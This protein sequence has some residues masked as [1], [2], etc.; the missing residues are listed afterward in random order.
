MKFECSACGLRLNSF[1]F[2]KE[3]LLNPQLTS[4]C[5][6]CLMRNLDPEDYEN[7]VIQEIAQN[8]LYGFLG[9]KSEKVNLEK[10]HYLV[11]SKLRKNFESLI[12]D[13]DANEV[14]QKQISR[15]DFNLK[16]IASE[17]GE[18][19]R[20]ILNGDLGA[21]LQKIGLEA[22][23]SLNE[24]DY[25]DRERIRHKYKYRCQ[26]CGRRGTSVDHKDPVSLSGNN[27]LDNLILA[28][29]ECNKIKSNMS[30]KLFEELNQEVT[31]LNKKLVAYENLLANL[32]EKFESNKRYI[33]GQ[34]H[35]KGIINDPELNALRKQNKKLQDA[36]DGL[37]SDYASLRKVRKLHFENGWK[38]QQLQ[39]EQEI[40]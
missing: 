12:Q 3:R 22:D 34:V 11:K 33:A 17:D 2:K 15:Q 4:I 40:I 38:L 6:I 35:L 18:V 8:M 36:I 19:E 26:Y 39:E 23:F 21:N 20:P 1:H 13:F 9:K 28:C 31:V 24:I 32:K 7:P 5:D 10:M 25:I 16:I 29:E 14:A 30:Y 37:S 27:N